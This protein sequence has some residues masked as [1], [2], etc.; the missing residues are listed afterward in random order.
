MKKHIVIIENDTDILE[1]MGYILENEGY[2]VTGY[3]AFPSMAEL[4]LMHADCFIIDEWL[5]NVSGHAICLLLKARVSSRAVPVIL[6]STTT[7]IEPVASLCEA[8]ASLRKPFD[9]ESLLYVVS[10]V[11]ANPLPLSR[12]EG[13]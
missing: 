7:D 5:P 4:F 10:S 3:K 1:V 13:F 12:A 11:L 6:A 2:V 9:I 8:D